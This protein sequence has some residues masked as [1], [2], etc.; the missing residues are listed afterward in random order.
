MNKTIKLDLLHAG[1][2]LVVTTFTPTCQLYPNLNR[3]PIRPSKTNIDTNTTVLHR[4]FDNAQC[5]ESRTN[6]FMLQPKISVYHCHTKKKLCK[7]A[8]LPD[9]Q[10]P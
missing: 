2:M 10:I 3:A 9:Y 7:N 4:M 1:T 6:I 5:W 8:A